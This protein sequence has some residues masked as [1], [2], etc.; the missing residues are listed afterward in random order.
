MYFC[1]RFAPTFETFYNLFGPL[2]EEKKLH[3][4]TSNKAKGLVFIG[5]KV[6]LNQIAMNLLSNSVKYTPQGGTVSFEIIGTKQADMMINLQIIIFDNGIGMSEEFQKSMF[7]PFAQ[8]F[9][10]PQRLKTASGTGLG[11]AI[12]Q[13]LTELMDGKISVQSKLKEGSKFTCSFLFEEGEKEMVRKDESKGWASALPT[14]SGKLLL[15]EDNSMNAEIA[16]RLLENYGYKVQLAEDGK[17]AAEIFS[18][19]KS[20]EYTAILMDIQMPHLNGYEAAKAIRALAR[21]DAK[22]IPIIAMTADAFAEDIKHAQEV[23]MNGHVSKP[24]DPERFYQVL[25]GSISKET[26]KDTD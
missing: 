18:N 6:R 16:I 21:E 25:A 12:V 20:E 5:D 1:R 23:G 22:T 13:R 4:V 19:S 3:F 9:D 14:C 11:L 24:I 10:N 2:C 7:Q 26:K 8:E 17:R 15:A